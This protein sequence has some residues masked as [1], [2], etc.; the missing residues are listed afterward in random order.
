[1]TNSNQMKKTA[2]I[3]I[4]VR[5]PGV[6]GKMEFGV[7]EDATEDFDVKRMNKDVWK[8]ALV[9]GYA[10]PKWWQLWRRLTEDRPNPGELEAAQAE[11]EA[12]EGRDEI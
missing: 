8:V 10:R 1:M 4:R 7:F 2:R 12:V 11:L 6:R 3:S 9:W 5:I